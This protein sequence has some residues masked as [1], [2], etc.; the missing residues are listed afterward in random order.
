MKSST[1]YSAAY[2]ATKKSRGPAYC[3]GDGDIYT[4][5]TLSSSLTLRYQRYSS[6]N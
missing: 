3:P 6:G 1:L 5:H 2:R 4:A